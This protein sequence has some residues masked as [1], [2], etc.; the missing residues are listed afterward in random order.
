MH[1][2]EEDDDDLNHSAL[3]KMDCAAAPTHFRCLHALRW[4]FTQGRVKTA[5]ERRNYYY[6]SDHFNF[7]F[8][9][10]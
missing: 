7:V 3:L 4:H 10:L 9:L 1:D 2:D 8:L 6:C 5:R